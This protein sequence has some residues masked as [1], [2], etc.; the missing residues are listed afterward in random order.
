M[1]EADFHQVL[2]VQNPADVQ[3]LQQWVPGLMPTRRDY[4]SQYFDV[5]R[6][7]LAYLKPVPDEETILQRF[8]DKMP[9]R[10][11]L[12]TGLASNAGSKRK[13]A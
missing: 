1:S 7:E 12:F 13:R 6:G 11:K 3:R 10:V 9:R 8:D 4:H 5:A 2:H